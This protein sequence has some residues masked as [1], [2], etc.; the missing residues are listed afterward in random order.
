[1][2]IDTVRPDISNP[3]IGDN[4]CIG[5]VCQ[6]ESHL[7]MFNPQVVQSRVRSVPF[8][9]GYA[10]I[11]ITDQIIGADLEIREGNITAS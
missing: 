7:G 5:L 1:M 8:H 6:P 3:G 4:C 11:I 10:V 9:R 2:K